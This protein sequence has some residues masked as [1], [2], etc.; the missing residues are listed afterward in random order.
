MKSERRH[1]LQ[2]NSL[3]H[4]LAGVPFLARQYGSQ[5][6][7][8]L[9][10]VLL[11]IVLIRYRIT[12]SR[13]TAIRAGDSLNVARSYIDQLKEAALNVDP[14]RPENVLTVIQ[15]LRDQA[16][17]QLTIVTED[18]TD[19]ILLAEARVA[20]GD[21]NWQLANLPPLP[22]AA[23]RPALALEKSDEQ[24]FQA[25]AESYAEVLND[26][27]APVSSKVTARL[28][29]AAIAENGR[30][31][32]DAQA[33]YQEV[34]DDAAAGDAFQA[35]ARARLAMLADLKTE[36]LIGA[37]ETAPA[38]LPDLEAGG[39]PSFQGPP[40]PA[41]AGSTTN[42]ATAPAGTRPATGPAATGPATTSP[43]TTSPAAAGTAAAKPAATAPAP[44]TI[45]TPPAP[46]ATSPAPASGAGT[47][48]AP[49]APQAPAAPKQ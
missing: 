49:T 30:K 42:A 27:T 37:P 9:I 47:K 16:E 39:F 31:W 11:V 2:T 19:P 14:A 33:R 5:I 18:S 13:E 32:D 12:Q 22:G 24:L 25:A 1:Q 35:H 43:A 48:P 34:I 21:L 15:N 45:P 20:R 28:S 36:P 10:V 3:D 7:L 17:Q 23:T 4:V 40:A 38:G 29:L 46:A 26:A 8:G 6:L 41:T 44:T